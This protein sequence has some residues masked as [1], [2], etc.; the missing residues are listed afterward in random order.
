VFDVLEQLVEGAAISE[1]L[2]PMLVQEIRS[3]NKKAVVK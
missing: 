3:D 1:E 2:Q